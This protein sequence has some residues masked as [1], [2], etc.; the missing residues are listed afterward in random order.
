MT[1]D[2][3]M[4]ALESMGTGQNRKTYRNHGAGEKVFGVSF[5]N[6]GALKKKIKTDHALALALW[7]TGNADARSLATMIADPQ[8][9]TEAQ[10][11]AWAASIDFYVHAGLLGR[12]VAAASPAGLKRMKHWMKSKHDFTGEAGWTALAVR[13]MD[14]EGGAVSDEECARHL[15]TIEKTIHKAANRTRYA[16]NNALIAIGGRGSKLRATALAA[17]RRIGK[18]EVDHGNTG[19][20]TPEAVAYIARAEARKAA[21]AK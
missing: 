20:K 18:V 6:L 19:C 5:A 8:A 1:F 16:M 12:H 4:A 3:T 15:E 17:A 13:V 7:E 21:R 14:V 9:V 2:E 10:L 11:D